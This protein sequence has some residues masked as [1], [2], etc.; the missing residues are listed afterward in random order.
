[1]AIQ[2]PVDSRKTALT[3]TLSNRAVS[4]SGSSEKSFESGGVR[5]SHIM[6]PRSGLPVQGVLSVAGQ[7]RRL[8]FQG[9]HMLMSGEY[10]RP[11]MADDKRESKFVFI[12]RNLPE[13]TFRKGLQLCVA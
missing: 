8:V 10:G 4:V 6:D 12:G 11:W 13:E 7:N 2:D 9:V 5:Y 3:V 1:M